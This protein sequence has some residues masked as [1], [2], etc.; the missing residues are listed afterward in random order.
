MKR[1]AIYLIFLLIP[2]LDTAA[3]SY[4]VRYSY[5][6]KT[7]MQSEGYRGDMDMRVDVSDGKAVW[8][9]EKTYLR[10]SLMRLAFDADGEIINQEIYNDLVDNYRSGEGM[11]TFLDFNG[12]KLTQCRKQ[13]WV[14][15]N[16]DADLEM[17]QWEITDETTVSRDGYNVRKAV[18]DYMGREWTVWYTEEIP[19]PYGPWLFH[20]LPGLVIMAVDSEELFI[21]RHMG[22][23]EIDNFDRYDTLWNMRHLGPEYKNYDV[24]NYGLEEAEKMYTRLLT[25]PGYK[26]EIMGGTSI[27]SKDRNGNPIP[28]EGYIPIIPNKYWKSR[29]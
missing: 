10:D 16:G 12:R 5:Q 21:F 28:P 11:V 23:E 8:Y 17:P 26:T 19:L 15:I 20:G 14:Y 24:F 27:S 6:Y 18:A 29:K 3:Q 22:M 1:I 25:D 13:M 9:S 2:V 7:D 4:R